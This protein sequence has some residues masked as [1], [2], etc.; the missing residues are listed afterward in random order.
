MGP[1]LHRLGQQAPDH[2]DQRAITFRAETGELLLSARLLFSGGYSASFRAFH[3][4]S[5]TF[6][7]SSIWNNGTATTAFNTATI[8]VVGR[9]KPSI[10]ASNVRDKTQYRNW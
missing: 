10:C 8:M 6:N 4:Y 3:H 1:L 2:I 9:S 7:L 5:V